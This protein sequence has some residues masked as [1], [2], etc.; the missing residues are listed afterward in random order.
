M[1]EL[2]QKLVCMM[3][4]I[5]ICKEMNGY[6]IESVDIVVNFKRQIIRDQKVK[7][8]DVGKQI[9]SVINDVKVEQEMVFKL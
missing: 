5:V 2:C 9:Q 4:V 3:C 1:K 7:M 6:K 8:E